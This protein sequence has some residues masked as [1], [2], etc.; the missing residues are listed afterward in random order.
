LEGVAYVKRLRGSAHAPCSG[1]GKR[2][3]RPRRWAKDG[4]FDV[5]QVRIEK[6][7]KMSKMKVAPNK[8]LKT[9]GQKSDV[10]DYANKVVKTSELIEIRY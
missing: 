9:K 1:P 7:Q 2:V 5:N 3:G 10:M 8:L 6:N 4:L